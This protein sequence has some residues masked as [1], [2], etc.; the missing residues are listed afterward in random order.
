LAEARRLNFPSICGVL[1][2]FMPRSR[3]KPRMTPSS[4]LPQTTRTSAIGELVIHILAPL[5]RQPPDALVAR[6]VMP[7]GSEPWSGSVRPKQ[8]TH[9]PDA[10]LGRYF[11]RCASLPK[12]WIG[13]I[14]RL[15][16]TLIAER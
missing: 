1:S 16:C 15:D 9:S 14:T 13:Y 4:V 8:P 7:E 11:C 2:P 12:A 10:N 3:I 6:V 5:S